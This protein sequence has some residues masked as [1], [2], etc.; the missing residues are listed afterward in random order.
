MVERVIAYIDGFNLYFGLKDKGWKQLYWLDVALLAENLLKPGQRL[1]AVKYFTARISGPPS[2]Q[3]RQNMFLEATTELGKCNIYYGQYFHVPRECPKC[4]CK[5]QVPE[6]KMTDVNIAVEMMADAQRDAFDTALLV[7]ADSDLTPPV[8]RIK[9]LHKDKKV[10]AA[11]PPKRSSKRLAS[12]VD[13]NFRIGR[14]KLSKSL[15]PESITKNDG[16]IINRPSRWKETKA[17]PS[18]NRGPR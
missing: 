9:E 4:K 12:M 10:V 1:V 6:E 11:F 14:G 15:L 5:Y 3:H 16:V 2:K 13:A 7:S 17:A 18:P 8:E